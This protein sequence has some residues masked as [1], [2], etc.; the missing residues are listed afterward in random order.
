MSG[1][2]ASYDD[3]DDNCDRV[4]VMTHTW[5]RIDPTVNNHSSGLDPVRLHHLSASNCYYY[6]ISFTHL[7]AHIHVYLNTS[8]TSSDR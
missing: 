1:A 7:D 5:D 6:N 8:V 3:D 2:I 4:V